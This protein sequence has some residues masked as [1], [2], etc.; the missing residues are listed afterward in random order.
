MVPGIV[1]LGGTWRAAHRVWGL[2]LWV[3]EA[4]MLT[5]TLVWAVLIVLYGRK[6]RAAPEAARREVDDPIQCCFI[7]LIGVTTSLV[8]LAVLPYSRPFAQALFGAG[9]LF[10]LGFALWR[11]G[12]L[13]Q[14]GRDH[15]TTTPVLYLPTVAGAFVTAIGAAALGGPDWGQLA[16]GAGVF[17]WLAIESVLLHRLYT[18]SPLPLALRPVLGIQLAPPTVGAVAYLSVTTGPPGLA[19]HLLLGYGL[20]QALILL[21]LLPWITRQPFAPSYWA[22]SF[23]VTALA[24]APLEMIERGDSGVA[25]LL[26]PFLFVAANLVLILLTVATLRLA[27]QGRLLPIPAKTTH[28]DH[29]ENHTENHADH[30]NG[31]Y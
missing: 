25:A 3:G 16:F 23:G 12:G 29:A 28:A 26:A 15:Q 30:A 13:W 5:G 1:G 31:I 24:T 27:A 10:T 17:S 19:A 8:A 22:F 7:G 21:R 9:A 4:L 6:W 2:P 14:G 18:V 11:T 20:L